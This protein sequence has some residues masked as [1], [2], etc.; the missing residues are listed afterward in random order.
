MPAFNS[1]TP[2][3]NYKVLGVPLTIPHVFAA[4][5]ALTEEEARF[6][7]RQLASVT[8]NAYGGDVR[9][10]MEKI[11][12]G[13]LEA[14]KAGTYTGPTFT[15][16]VRGKERTSPVLITQAAEL[17]DWDHQAKIDAKFTEYEVGVSQRGGGGGGATDP[18]EAIIERLASTAVKDI[19]KRKGRSVQ[20]FMRTKDEEHGSAFKRIVA[21][22]TEGHRESLQALAEAQM[23]ALTEQSGD[24]DDLDLGPDLGEDEDEEQAAA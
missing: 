18:M 8:V 3:G 24:G 17:P 6:V 12:E 1:E 9:R 7:N 10:A 19:I 23:A 21:E 20:K 13:R 22:Y 2:K 16:T 14:Y 15:E 4:G 5:H 11:N